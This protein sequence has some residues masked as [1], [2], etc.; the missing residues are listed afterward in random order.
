LD[1]NDVVEFL[2]Q[3]GAI[4]NVNGGDYGSAIQAAA[5]HGNF[6][7]ILILIRNNANVNAQ[8]GEWGNP[9]RAAFSKGH[10]HAAWLLL[11]NGA[12]DYM[13][14]EEFN[15]TLKA[16]A[17]KGLQELRDFMVDKCPIESDRSRKLKINTDD[18]E[19]GEAA[20]GETSPGQAALMPG[21]RSQE[22]INTM[23]EYISA[24]TNLRR[25]R[26]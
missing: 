19:R 23:N 16:V 3:K 2:L 24:E 13:R 4:V 25:S 10:I 12:Q 1:R 5:V 11:K 7:I 14:N 8:G 9:L 18:T 15:A 22:A 21:A 26:I 17:V 6:D 20:P